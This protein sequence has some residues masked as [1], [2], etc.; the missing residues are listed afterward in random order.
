VQNP[1]VRGAVKG[2]GTYSGVGYPA[3]LAYNCSIA[4]NDLQNYNVAADLTI[5]GRGIETW[6]A[7]QKADRI[8]KIQEACNRRI[9]GPDIFALGQVSSHNKVLIS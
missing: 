1:P 4:R 9:A 8:H 3:N 6:I 5:D 7:A 2:D